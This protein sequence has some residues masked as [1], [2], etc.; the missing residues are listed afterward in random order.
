MTSIWF[1]PRKRSIRSFRLSDRAHMR[2]ITIIAALFFAASP[3]AAQSW[4][5]Y[6]YPTDFFSVAFPADPKV[7]T[8]AYQAA[9]GRPVEARVYSVSQDGGVFR[10]TV[11]DLPDPAL[12]QPRVRPSAEHRGAGRQLFVGGGVLSQTTALSDRRDGASRRR[13]CN[14]RRHPVPAIA[15]LHRRFDKQVIGVERTT[16]DAAEMPLHA[17]RPRCVPSAARSRSQFV[18]ASSRAASVAK[19]RSRIKRGSRSLI[20]LRSHLMRARSTM[21]R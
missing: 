9:D 18:R 6:A 15:R 16:G 1:E 19:R 7:E 5:E 21:R 3:A 4:K 10:M 8:T 14:V 2:L 17:A 13:Q 12:H 20:S 11:A